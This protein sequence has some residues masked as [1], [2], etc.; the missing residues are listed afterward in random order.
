TSIVYVGP[1]QK[2]PGRLNFRD[3]L[4]YGPTRFKGHPLRVR[5]TMMVLQKNAADRNASAIDIIS[6]FAA[7][8]APQYSAIT[9]EVA[10]VLHGI[11]K[12]QPDIKFFDFEA[13][14]LSDEPEALAEIIPESV[15]KAQ[16]G[17]PSRTFKPDQ[18]GADRIH[19]LR[20]GRYALVE[21][22]SHSGWSSVVVDV[23]PGSI[24]VEDG[25]LRDANG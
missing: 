25:W 9:S 4:A 12:A 3:M 13:T 10:K 24:T 14:L 17:E 11:L 20:Y 23:T 16:S 15:P 22:E 6:S 7:A 21:T 18:A 1:N 5:F 8:A 19:W 2:V